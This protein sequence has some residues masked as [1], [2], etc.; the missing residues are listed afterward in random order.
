MKLLVVPAGLQEREVRVGNEAALAAKYLP[1]VRNAD[2]ISSAIAAAGLNGPEH[3]RKLNRFSRQYSATTMRDAPVLELT[4]DFADAE[5]GVRLIRAIAAEAIALNKV[6]LTKSDAES[7]AFLGDQLKQTRDRLRELEDRHQ[8]AARKARVEERRRE[9]DGLLTRIAAAEA[10]ASDKAVEAAE[11]V[12]SAAEMQKALAAQEKLI[13]LRRTLADD[14][15]ASAVSGGQP[16]SRPIV[17]EAINPLYQQIEPKLTEDRSK[18]AGAVAGRDHLARDLP[19]LR[20]SVQ[21]LLDRLRA[22]QLELER[23]TVDLELARAQYKALSEQHDRARIS[24]M[25]QSADLRVFEEARP[26]QS[27]VSPRTVPNVI[28]GSIAGLLIGAFAAIVAGVLVPRRESAPV[29]TGA[30]AAV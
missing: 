7:R 2:V 16:P 4:L 6:L 5:E 13:T 3:A 30:P 28:F 22:D 25:A 17:A 14:P 8:E 12:S 9:I 15:A 1:Y 29:R 20:A 19:R 27:P 24:V 10:N 26:G 23:V 11:L 18:L 21:A